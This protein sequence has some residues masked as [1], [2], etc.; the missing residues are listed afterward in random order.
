MELGVPDAREK[1][2]HAPIA[3]GAGQRLGTGGEYI[4][5]R[6]EACQ[7][8][9]CPVGAQLLVEDRK[10]RRQDGSAPDLRKRARCHAVAAASSRSIG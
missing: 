3:R 7:K 10:E 4:R 5:Q 9:A 8:R 6:G 2:R 1:V